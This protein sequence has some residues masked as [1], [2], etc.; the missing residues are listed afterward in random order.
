ME[1]LSV[2][3]IKI[4]FPFE[5]KE[6]ALKY[7]ELLLQSPE[8]YQL[9]F[10]EEQVI[11]TETSDISEFKKLILTKV[12]DFFN[13]LEA[14]EATL[15][16]TLLKYHLTKKN[17]FWSQYGV[18]T[19]YKGSA[20]YLLAAHFYNQA[21]PDNKISPT[22][23]FERSKEDVKTLEN[24]LEN[25]RESNFALL[26]DLIEQ[27]KI[28]FT[29]PLSMCYD[30]F[31]AENFSHVLT[32]MG[33]YYRLFLKEF[34]KTPSRLYRTPSLSKEELENYIRHFL[35]KTDPS[36]NWLTMYETSR[37]DGKLIFD[38]KARHLTILYKYK[39]SL[40]AELTK[41]I[42]DFIPMTYFLIKFIQEEQKNTGKTNEYVSE[43]CSTYYEELA[44]EF[45][46]E[47]DYNAKLINILE[48]CR[49]QEI[50]EIYKEISPIM[51][52]IAEKI[53]TGEPLTYT[54]V[55]A[56]ALNED[57]LVHQAFFGDETTSNKYRLTDIT[58]MCKKINMQLLNGK[59]YQPLSH[60]SFLIGNYLAH[61]TLQ[62][63]EGEYYHENIVSLVN[64]STHQDL[65]KLAEKL[66]LDQALRP[67]RPKQKIKKD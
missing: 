61:I 36:L 56:A 41:T 1:T 31:L 25:D 24:W 4:K 63:N 18:R 26:D 66:N 51:A 52:L 60:F 49:H 28:E 48:G 7:Q 15:K 10:K 47:K 58:K 17:N 21:N 50:V 44:E 5:K 22:I 55:A 9:L 62:N 20:F 45:L 32:T 46:R 19:P 14:S 12:E 30:K 34:E 11:I 54:N 35:V 40:Y 8:F 59:G 65:G 6:T 2:G 16:A 67:I 53:D 37:Q 33:A 3:S 39:N 57:S 42:I 23:L 64:N 13:N 43:F 29:S 27:Q 38:K